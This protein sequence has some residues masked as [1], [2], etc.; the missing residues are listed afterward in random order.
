MSPVSLL[1]IMLNRER[2]DRRLEKTMQS[3]TK[4]LNIVKGEQK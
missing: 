2:L 3:F 4:D 1:T